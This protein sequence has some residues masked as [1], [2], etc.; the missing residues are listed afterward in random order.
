MSGDF[1]ILINSLLYRKDSEKK[2]I[3]KIWCLLFKFPSLINIDKYINAHST[4]FKV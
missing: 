4:N 1:Q 3:T 2:V